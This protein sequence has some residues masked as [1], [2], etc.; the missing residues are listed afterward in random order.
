[1]ITAVAPVRVCD[2]GGWTDTWFGGPG[3]V[4]HLAVT[5][6]IEVSIDGAA[7]PDPVVLEAATFGDRYAMVPGADRTPRHPLLE[8]VVDAWP[9]PP[10]RPVAI[11][12]GSGVPPGCG[13]GTSA[14]VA[15][16]LI[17][18]L[19]ALRSDPVNPRNIAYAAHQIEVE[20]LGWQSG[21]QDQL[22]AAFGGIN[23]LEIDRYPEATVY[24]LPAWEELGAG[25]TL[26]FLGR[27]H[28]SSGVHDDVIRNLGSHRL[29]ALA[30]LRAAAV[31]ARAAVEAQDLEAFGQA[32]RANTAAQAALHPD[33]V[34][35]DAR[36]VIEMAVAR[37]SL[38]WKVNGAGGDGGSVTI[39][40]A[41]IEEKRSLEADVM[42]LDPRYQVIPIRIS[43]VGLQVTGSVY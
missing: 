10:G 28:H 24:P 41:G 38:G 21:V 19:A 12:V 16:A 30:Q 17:G 42:T 34:G 26:V 8:A 25:L 15:V 4:L 5:P 29:E 43:P 31:A 23:Y 14:A 6:G 39:L 36:R 27:S 40:S 33:L 18:A 22:S 37:Y 2:H 13:T 9:P 3:R 20:V 32:M 1:M 11:R 35:A 7:G